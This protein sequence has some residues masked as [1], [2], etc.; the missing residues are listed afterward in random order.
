VKRA[1][2]SLIVF[3]SLSACAS[4]SEYPYSRKTEFQIGDDKVLTSVRRASL[5]A[6][7][8]ERKTI[9]TANKPDNYSY[10]LQQSC[11]CLYGPAY[12]PNA[13]KVQDGSVKSIIYRGE[14]RDGFK[15]G[16][17]LSENGVL[18]YT[19]DELF[20]RI[21]RV[22][23]GQNLNPE[24]YKNREIIENFNVSYDDEFGFPIRI[25]YDRVLTADEE[26]V[27]LLEG[28]KLL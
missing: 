6:Q 12:G 2:A 28:F 4:V 15:S 16:D 18:N 10:I 11:F 5:K 9:W 1:V 20:E 3:S 8:A 14:T 19:I 13:I 22:L 17:K 7:L 27:I 24:R 25:S 26:Y 23:S 21:E